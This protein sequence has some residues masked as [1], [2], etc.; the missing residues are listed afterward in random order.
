M[1]LML[2]VWCLSLL[3]SRNHLY[4]HG[5]IQVAANVLSGGVTSSLFYYMQ[6]GKKNKPSVLLVPAEYS[7][8]RLPVCMGWGEWT[9]LNQLCDSRNTVLCLTKSQSQT[10]LCKQNG[11]VCKQKR[12]K[13]GVSQINIMVEIIM[14][15]CDACYNAITQ[16]VPQEHGGESASPLAHQMLEIRDQVTFAFVSTLLSTESTLRQIFKQLINMESKQAGRKQG[17]RFHSSDCLGSLQDTPVPGK[18]G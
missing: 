1:F 16:E 11:G 17:I 15:H 7:Q 12:Y 5:F 14:T 3:F 2:S 13:M 10:H 6:R 8:K 9:V 4:S 18:N